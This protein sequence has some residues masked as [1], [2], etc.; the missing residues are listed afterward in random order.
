M[1]RAFLCLPL[2]F[3][4]TTFFCLPLSFAAFLNFGGGAKSAALGGSLVAGGEDVFVTQIN[5][6][7]LTMLKDPQFGFE[8][9]KLFTGLSGPDGTVPGF[10]PVDLNVSNVALGIP[11]RKLIG[12]FGLSYTAFSSPNLYKEETIQIFMARTLND[13]ILKDSEESLG[14]GIG[15]KYLK[16]SV[17][18]DEYT[19]TFFNTN[20]NS[21]SGITM[22]IGSFY[23]P[24]PYVSIG[25]SLK[26]LLG[27]DV[28]IV[29][30]DQVPR[31]IIGG[32]FWTLPAETL[33][34][35][36]LISAAIS[37]RD[38]ELRA[39]Y[40]GGMEVDFSNFFPRIGFDRDEF[41]AGF[42]FEFLKKETWGLT[43]DYAFIF[44]ITV[45]GTT[46][47]HRVALKM[48]FNREK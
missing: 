14:I 34:Q 29:K 37:R 2:S 48:D 7:L 40:R 12:N 8:Y 32:L 16:R 43:L 23:M 35:R 26:N 47:S 18:P 25:I 17:E 24:L 44:P 13:L 31:E 28:G 10:H 15:L 42:G 5:P 3:I 1:K 19:Q 45:S 21:A 36:T 46:G 38:G 33:G 39:N 11:F 4:I 30:E 20:T 22:D 9:Q 27:A 41:S 6:S